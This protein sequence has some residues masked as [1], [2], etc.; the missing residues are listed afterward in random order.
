MLI[1]TVEVISE[2]AV[3]RIITLQIGIE[4]QQRYRVAGDAMKEIL[5]GA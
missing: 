1:A 2:S 5:P 4:K 3:P